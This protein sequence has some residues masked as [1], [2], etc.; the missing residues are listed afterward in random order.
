MADMPVGKEILALSIKDL[1]PIISI[2]LIFMGCG[3]KK[4]ISD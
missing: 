2:F 4:N 3:S 1:N